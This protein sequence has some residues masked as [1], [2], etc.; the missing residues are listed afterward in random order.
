MSF[1]TIEVSETDEGI[2]LHWRHHWRT[3]APAPNSESIKEL[4]WF[5]TD[6]L[7]FHQAERLLSYRGK[8]DIFEIVTELAKEFFG[9]HSRERIRR[10]IDLVKLLVAQAEAMP[11]TT[12]IEIKT[13]SAYIDHLIVRLKKIRT[14]AKRS[15]ILESWKK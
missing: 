7:E 8:T 3:F 11:R 4:R 6:W 5:L 1:Q 13:Y 14:F 2:M 15:L 12:E 10:D 9:D